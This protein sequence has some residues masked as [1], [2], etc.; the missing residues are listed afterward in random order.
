[1]CSSVFLAQCT[2]VL[3]SGTLPKYHWGHAASLAVFLTGWSTLNLSA[4]MLTFSWNLLR[5]FRWTQTDAFPIISSAQ[6][7]RHTALALAE[8]KT[9]TPSFPLVLQDHLVLLISQRRIRPCTHYPI[10]CRE[11]QLSPL[12]VFPFPFSL[13]ERPARTFLSKIF[14]A[15][16]S[17]TPHSELGDSRI[18]WWALVHCF[19]N[20]CLFRMRSSMNGLILA[21]TPQAWPSIPLPQLLNSHSVPSLLLSL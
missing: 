16:C 5:C 8:P 19:C 4:G 9:T 18:G 12:V 15:H 6:W 14:C 10:N 17:P 13:L 20:S 7:T 21:P 1:M 3:S 2:C 11:T